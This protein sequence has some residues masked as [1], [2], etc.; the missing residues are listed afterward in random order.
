MGGL[1]VDSIITPFSWYSMLPIAGFS[2][3]LLLVVAYQRTEFY[4]ITDKAEDVCRSLVARFRKKPRRRPESHVPWFIAGTTSP[5]HGIAMTTFQTHPSMTYPEEAGGSPGAAVL[6]NSA[7]AQM[8][9][10][11]QAVPL[12]VHGG[13]PGVGGGNVHTVSAVPVLI[14]VNDLSEWNTAI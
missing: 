5:A 7:T 12:H 4:W 1:I 11:H 13:A 2:F 6:L 10:A 14:K 3:F 9:S 8:N